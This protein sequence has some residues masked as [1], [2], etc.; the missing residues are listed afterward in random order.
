MNIRIALI[1]W[2]SKW[3]SILNI[4]YNIICPI[5]I[6]SNTLDINLTSIALWIFVIGKVIF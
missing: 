6:Y 3:R 4:I 5:G 1:N 2:N